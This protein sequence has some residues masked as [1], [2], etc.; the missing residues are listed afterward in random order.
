MGDWKTMPLMFILLDLETD[1][2]A[3]VL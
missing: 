2:I 3:E 1:C